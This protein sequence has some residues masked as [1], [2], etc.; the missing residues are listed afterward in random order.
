[1]L[2]KQGRLF[3]LC[4]TGMFCEFQVGLDCNQSPFQTIKAGIH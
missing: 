1:M 3:T 2:Q 4:E